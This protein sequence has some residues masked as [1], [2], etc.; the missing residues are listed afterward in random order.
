MDAKLRKNGIAVKCEKCN[1]QIDLGN[2]CSQHI[3]V[4]GDCCGCG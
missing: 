4:C 2:L 3:Y 1:E